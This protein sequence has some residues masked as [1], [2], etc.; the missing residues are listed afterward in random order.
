MKQLRTQLAEERSK[1]EKFDRSLNEERDRFEETIKSLEEKLRVANTKLAELRGGVGSGRISTEKQ[2]N[3]DN[4]NNDNN[5]SGV[6]Q[7]QAKYG[8][9]GQS[10]W[11]VPTT[12]DDAFFSSFAGGEGSSLRVQQVLE[13][14]QRQIHARTE[15]LEIANGKIK[16]LEATRDALSE[17]L[18]AYLLSED[19]GS[20]FKTNGQT[21]LKDLANSEL[22]EEFKEIEKRYAVVLELL[23]EKDEEIEDLK[24]SVSSLKELVNAL[25]LEQIEE[26]EI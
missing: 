16:R 14:A 25:S 3:N 24:D 5:N 21:S 22:R 12:L 23:G 15:Q 18:T 20:Y 6:F 2:S 13:N 17:E 10:M 1:T 9:G 11:T 4:I 8:K 19:D 26:I 7:Q